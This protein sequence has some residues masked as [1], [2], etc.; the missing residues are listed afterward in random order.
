MKYYKAKKPSSEAA[1][2]TIDDVERLTEFH[3]RTIQRMYAGG[4]FPK[5]VKSNWYSLRWRPS[6][7]RKWLE[8]VK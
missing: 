4:L 3:R 7:V 2:L 6:E 5:P 1:T 8:A